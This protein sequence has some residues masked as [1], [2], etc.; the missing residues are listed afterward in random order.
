M[1]TTVYKL[2][3]GAAPDSFYLASRN[4]TARRLYHF[5][6]KTNRALRY[7]RNQKSPFE[8]EQDGNFI[9]EPI[10]F[11]NGFLTVYEDNPVLQHFL[12]VHPD[13]G[14]LFEEVNNQKDAQ[15]E[16][17]YYELEHEAT[18][19]VRSMDIST[20]ESIARVALEIDPSKMTT[21]ELKR[22]MYRF[23]R[24]NPQD[25]LSMANDP[26]IAHEGFV[27]KLFDEGVL[28]ARKN[29]VHYNLPTNKSKMLTVP[30]DQTHHSAVSSFFLT[31]EGA[32]A[33]K[34]LEKFVSV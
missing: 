22:D 30:L 26:H 1:K 19:R 31:E 18:A 9:L 17:D 14:K 27:A 10:V 32:D 28:S 7:A 13:N 16:I 23:A 2:I 5:D 34:V 6:G 15:E 29:A 21:S 4:T 12:S 20:L 3:G 24:N 11:E 8:D 33:M 25:L